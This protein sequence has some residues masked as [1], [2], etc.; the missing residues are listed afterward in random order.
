MSGENESAL[1][2]PRR[3]GTSKE[4]KKSGQGG[5][6]KVPSGAWRKNAS[7]NGQPAPRV[8]REEHPNWTTR[9]RVRRLADKLAAQEGPLQKGKRASEEK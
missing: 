8:R 9:P 6:E 3:R 1:R 7:F 4:K 5:Q 2:V